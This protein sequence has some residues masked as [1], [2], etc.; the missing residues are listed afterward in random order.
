MRNVTGKLIIC[1]L[2]LAAL[3]SVLAFAEPTAYVPE[4]D[5]TYTIGYTEASASKYYAIL[6][7]KGVYADG[8][9]PEISEDS[10]L[11]IDQATAGSSGEVS[12]SGFIPRTND[13]ASVY[14]GSNAEGFDGPVLLGYIGVQSNKFTVSGKVSTD[15]ATTYEATVTLTNGEETFT[16]VT[17]AGTYSVEVP[18][19]SYT[20]K[21]EVK[22]HLSYTKNELAVEDDV[23]KNVTLLG[24]DIDGSGTVEFVDLSEVLNSYTQTGEADIDGS[25]TVEFA[26]LSIILNNYTKT[27]TVE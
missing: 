18:E 3:M 7:V 8:E 21:V 27:A 25:G 16:A 14:L 26:D 9:T 12:F 6:V 13:P 19:G 4:A 2:V 5:G 1:A 10:V 20:F 23:T 22:N 24:G 17:A 15:S 11:Y